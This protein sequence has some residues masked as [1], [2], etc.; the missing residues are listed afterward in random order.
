MSGV[1][2]LNYIQLTWASHIGLAVRC[3]VNILSEPHIHLGFQ[4]R[5]IWLSKWS[6]VKCLYL[7]AR[8]TVIANTIAL[9]Y[10]DFNRNWDSP[11]CQLVEI[12]VNIFSGLGIGVTEIILTIRTNAL[13]G[14][15]KNFWILSVIAWLV[16][17]GVGLWALRTV[18]DRVQPTRGN[19]WVAPGGSACWEAQGNTILGVCYA[20]HSLYR[21]YC[22]LSILQS[23]IFGIVILNIV[24]QSVAP[25]A[26]KSIANTPLR[27]LHSIFAC[28]L[29]IHLR[30]VAADD[31]RRSLIDIDT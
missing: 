13:Y 5:Y 3:R 27:V 16:L 8:Y 15:P 23:L 24:V 19:R 14:R 31:L 9:M 20:A 2:T 11:S 30:A 29:V 10:L 6:S 28:Y 17:S 12:V 25:P 21:P 26:L 1:T 18:R 4:Y 22:L 7:W